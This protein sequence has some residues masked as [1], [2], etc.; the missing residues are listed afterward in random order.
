MEV[1]D[2]VNVVIVKAQQKIFSGESFLPNLYK[3]LFCFIFGWHEY[4]R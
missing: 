4:L 1:K 3:Y 2:T